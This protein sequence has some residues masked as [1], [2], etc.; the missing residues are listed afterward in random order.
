MWV[1]FGGVVNVWVCNW[2]YS[3]RGTVPDQRPFSWQAIIGWPSIMW[4]GLQL[5]CTRSPALYTPWPCMYPFS[6]TLGLSQVTSR[7]EFT[8]MFIKPYKLYHRFY[9]YIL[10]DF[11]LGLKFNY[12]DANSNNRNR[13]DHV[14]TD[15]Y[16]LKNDIAFLLSKEITTIITIMKQSM[17]TS[18]P[19]V[20]RK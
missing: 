2:N 3:Q 17:K 12:K 20:M 16:C 8:R 14:W 11:E 15:I 19:S 9:N 7:R 6:G 10:F 1:P 13:I 18:R 4:S 5:N